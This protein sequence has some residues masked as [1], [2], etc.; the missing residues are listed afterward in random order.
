M[1]GAEAVRRASL[2]LAVRSLIMRR[3]P[4]P[5]ACG[6]LGPNPNGRVMG[7]C[8]PVQQEADLSRSFAVWRGAC[9]AGR[10]LLGFLQNGWW[11][12]MLKT[13]VHAAPTRRCC[14]GDLGIAC[15]D[16]LCQLILSLPGFS[17]FYFRI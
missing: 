9:P 7:T 11:I 10:V 15:A 16:D 3:L 4:G 2:I 14:P 6:R 12:G 13:R 1:G 8:A 5:G 17:S